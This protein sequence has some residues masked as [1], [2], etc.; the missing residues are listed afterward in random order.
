MMPMEINQ[1]Y[2]EKYGLDSEWELMRVQAELQI[3]V[4]MDVI[5]DSDLDALEERRTKKN[6]TIKK[7]LEEGK[8]VYGTRY[9]TPAMYLQYELTRVKLD[10]TVYREEKLGPYTLHKVTEEEK[11]AFYDENRDLF[12]RYFGDSFRYEE[13]RMIIEK[14]L[15]EKEYENIVQDILC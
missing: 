4:W 12:T 7:E 5:P 9:Y 8:T 14:R 6:Q 3:A 11:K 15:K 10:F 13:V 1:A 2:I